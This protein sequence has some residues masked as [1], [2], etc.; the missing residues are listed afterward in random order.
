MEVFHDHVEINTNKAQTSKDHESKRNLF[1]IT[2]LKRIYEGEVFCQKGKEIID[3]YRQPGC[4]MP[5]LKKDSLKKAS[6]KKSF[7]HLIK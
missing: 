4:I 6:L 7:S 3:R 2:E 5:F 1:I